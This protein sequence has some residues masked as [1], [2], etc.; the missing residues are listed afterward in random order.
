MRIKMVRR[1]F[2]FRWF[3]EVFVDE[4]VYEFRTQPNADNAL[5]LT[6]SFATGDRKEL[7]FKMLETVHVYF[8]MFASQSGIPMRGNFLLLQNGEQKY[9]AHSVNGEKVVPGTYDVQLL[10]KSQPYVQKNVVITS[11]DEGRTFSFEVPVGHVTFRYQNADGSPA[12]D[13][14]CFAGRKGDKKHYQN[15]GEKY[16]YRPGVYVVEGWNGNYDLVTFEVK[17]GEDIEVV[18]RERK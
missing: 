11:A 18:I 12:A 7:V 1:C 3:D 6:E 2:S 13:K 10:H 16:P 8:K 9:K 14:R 5:K 17:E 15:S 4:G